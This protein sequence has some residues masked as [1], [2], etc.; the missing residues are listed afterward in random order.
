MNRDHIYIELKALEKQLKGISPQLVS[1]GKLRDEIKRLRNLVGNQKAP[2][3]QSNG[4]IDPSKP[5]S[6][7]KKAGL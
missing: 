4:Y 5:K 6:M 7:L 1:Y 2:G 3:Y